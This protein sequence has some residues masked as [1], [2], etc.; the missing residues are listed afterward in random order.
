MGCSTYCCWELG[1]FCHP[2]PWVLKGFGHSPGVHLCS[3]LPLTGLRRDALRM[4]LRDD[5]DFD[6]SLPLVFTGLHGSTPLRDDWGFDSTQPTLNELFLHIRAAEQSLAFLESAAR[7]LER[8]R[9]GRLVEDLHPQRVILNV[10][11]LVTTIYLPSSF[12][13]Y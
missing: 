11:P 12:M 9:V 5:W 1:F 8:K 7:Y 6:S 4:N 3:G 10:I 13:T 2:S